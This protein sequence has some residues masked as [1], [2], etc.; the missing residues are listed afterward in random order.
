VTFLACVYVLV[1]VGALV[2]L[3]P[4]L[5]MITTSLKSEIDAFKFPPVWIPQPIVWQNY[6]SI[7]SKV[8]LA[9]VALN[10]LKVSLLVT[11]GALVSC[12]ASGFAFARLRFWG[13]DVLFTIVLATLMVPY[14]VTLIPTFLLY[15]ELGWINTHYPLWVP[16]WFG[17]AFGMFLMRQ[18]YLTI[19]KELEEAAKVDGSNPFGI[20]W[21]IFLPLGGP[22]LA[23]LAIFS[24]LGSWNNLLL[25]LVFLQDQNL[26]TFPVA[27]T[28]FSGQY[29]AD[30]PMMMTA[31]LISIVPTLGL[32]LLLQKY[33][34]QGVVLSGLK[35]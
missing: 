29:Y 26:M 22:V 8:P 27:L 5:Y 13:R 34:V 25:P 33:F 35:A 30:L 16:S 4:F 19:P 1:S 24:F 15:R 2:M 7:W 28:W 23:T 3:I 18:F 17:G 32:F 6:V 9:Q 12:S 14:Q 11:L 31:A 20:Y 10:S 21:R